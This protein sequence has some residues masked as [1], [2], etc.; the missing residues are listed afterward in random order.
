MSA[1]SLSAQRRADQVSLRKLLWAA[2]LAGVLAALGNLA[3]YGLARAALGLPLEMPAMGPTPAGSLSV[4]PVVLSSF[5]PAL[6]AGG[7]LAVLARFAARPLRVFQIVAGA[8]LVLSLG[9]P[10]TLPVDLGTRLVL[11]VM[12]L[13]A[14]LVITGVLSTTAVD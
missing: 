4:A 12:H 1:I 5:V 9:A 7:L 8:V 6:F 2:P 11:L 10:L 3:V 13:V 14:G